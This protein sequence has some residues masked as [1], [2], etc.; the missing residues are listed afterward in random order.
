MPYS[1][2]FQCIDTECSERMSLTE[3]VYTCPRCDGLL[4]VSHDVEA[5]KNRSGAAWMKLFDDRYM[6]TQFPYGSG[7][8]G[9]KEWVYPQI[10]D[11]NIVSTYEGG[12][13]L[14]RAIRFGEMIGVK[15]LWIKQSGN[16]HTGSFKDLGMTVLVSAVQQMIHE[17][18]DI[19]AVICASTGDTSAAVAAYCA[20]AGIPSVV[21]LPKDKVTTSQL[22]Q[23]LANGALTL[24]LDTDF[25]GC[26][27]VVKLLSEDKRFYLAN[28][29]NPLRI[30]GQKTISIEIVQQD[31]WQ[32]PDWV[33]VPSGNLGNITAIGLGFQMMRELGLIN[34]L[35]RLVAAQAAAA[36]PLYDSYK[37]G[38]TE[39]KPV[40]A[41]ATQATAIQIGNPVSAPRAI[42]ILQELTAWSSRRPKTSCHRQQP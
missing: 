36:A 24:A 29:I 33:I 5:L 25:D 27:E 11:A 26:M 23:P 3:I 8:W 10:D 7:V 14:F 2:W 9:K 15:D 34:K 16:S 6:T 28:S 42:P 39:Y 17:G 1:S 38:F 35:P 30:E 22:V 37:T 13:N 31:D 41:Q 40:R 12:S 18:T 32:T 20:T 19:R 4:M 21:L